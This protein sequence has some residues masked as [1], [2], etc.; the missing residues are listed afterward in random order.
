MLFKYEKY[1]CIKGASFK[2]N[3]FLRASIVSGFTKPLNLAKIIVAGSPGIN[4]G[5]KKL[6]VSAA[7]A[8]IK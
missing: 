1:C 4:L 7:Q 2:P 3:V 8:A 5:M 6:S